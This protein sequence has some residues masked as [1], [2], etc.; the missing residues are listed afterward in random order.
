MLSNA[1]DENT[2]KTTK[3]DATETWLQAA[4][5]IGGY[6]YRKDRASSPINGL[7][8]LVRFLEN[9]HDHIPY[10]F[11]GSY[12]K[13]FNGKESLCKSS[14]RYF[15][16]PFRD[17]AYDNDFI[18]NPPPGMPTSLGQPDTLLWSEIT[19]DEAKRLAGIN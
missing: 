12:V 14:S 13:L 11:L 17:V 15:N 2:S 8:N 6:S 5:L 10:H 7:H 19:W 4:L 9:W 16:A 18:A 3:T 1:W